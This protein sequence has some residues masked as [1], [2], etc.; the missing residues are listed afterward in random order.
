MWAQIDCRLSPRACHST[1][2][3]TVHQPLRCPAAF[4]GGGARG[5][6]GPVYQG[7][8]AASDQEHFKPPRTLRLYSS[9]IDCS[10]LMP[11]N[12]S[13][14][15]HLSSELSPFDQ[16]L[17]PHLRPPAPGN[18]FLCVWLFVQVPHV[19]DIQAHP[20]VTKGNSE[21]GREGGL[22]RGLGVRGRS[23][24][25][26]GGRPTAACSVGAA[27]RGAREALGGGRW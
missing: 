1:P 23:W 19:G 9:V 12:S 2:G 20:V 7:G 6:G 3:P 14:L 22:C 21:G 26:W 4:S 10:L 24:T 11:M 18:L 15:L 17:P 13:V 5:R 16:P 25:R 8:C 27:V